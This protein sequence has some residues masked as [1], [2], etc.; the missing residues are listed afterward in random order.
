[1]P[2][3]TTS[4][5][6]TES[7]LTDTVNRVT[8]HLSAAAARRMALSAQG[9]DRAR[10]SA[11]T[12]RHVQSTLQ[13]LGVLQI[14][15]VNVFAR[16]H[17]MPLLARLGAYDPGI[18]DDL[19]FTRRSPY[20]EYWAHEATFIPVSDWNLWHFRMQAMREKYLEPWER[21]NADTVNWVR[22]ELATRGPLRPADIE[23]DAHRAARG[24]WWDWSAV[25]QTLE[26]LFLAGE[27][28]IAGRTGFQR[29]YAL[30]EDVIGNSASETPLARDDAIRELVA[31]A[32]RAYGV[33]TTADIADYYRIRDRAAVTI[34]LQELTDAGELTPVTVEGWT[35]RQRVIP[36]WRY[37]AQR[38]PRSINTTAILS[39]FDPV[40]WFRDR[41]SRLFD[42][43][44]RIEIYTPAPKR[45]YGYYSL[46]ILIDDQI[47]G[48]V[49][50]KAERAQSRMLVQ[51]AWWEHEAHADHAGRVA[52][53]LRLLAA[54]QGLEHFSV[55]T[56][57]TAAD[58]IA[59]ALGR[60]AVVPR[61]AKTAG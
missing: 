61:H 46:P 41:A 20:T 9:F 32:M 19:V 30:A 48:R 23:D 43:D 7:V 59:A 28:A 58:D 10:P 2:E 35:S 21:D 6:S 27:V 13:R 51:S 4:W 37:N 15:S 40:V 12:R 53:E 22:D 11:V 8:D 54:W 3:L 5:A 60:R 29:H 26:R 49:D 52:D 36:A 16:S 47:V 57:G 25:K 24:P 33:A 14:D 50:L 18:L 1:M 45:V 17:Y 55:G 56:W 31:R 38:V 39:P 34:A 44:Y 42:F